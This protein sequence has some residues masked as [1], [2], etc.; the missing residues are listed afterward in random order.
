MINQTA[1]E[2][3]TERHSRLLDNWRGWAILF[4]LAG[5]FF[6]MRGVNLG[7]LGVELFFALSGRLMADLLFVKRVE[8]G[9]FFY[10][11]ITRVIPVSWLFLVIALIFF[12][13]GPIHLDVRSALASAA[14]VVNYTHLIGIGAQVVDHYWSLCI[15]E[16]SYLVLGSMAWLFRRHAPTKLR[17]ATVCLVL[18]A[19]MMLNGWRLW[20]AQHD[21]YAVY[22]RSDVRAATIFASVGLRLAFVGGVPTAWRAPWI[23]FAALVLGLA[24]NVNHV[25]DPIKY[26]AGSLSIALAIN[27][28]EN[29]WPGAQR[30]L[31]ARPIAWFGLI[32]YSLYIWQQPFYYCV[33]RYGAVP[34]LAGALV[35]ATVVSYL[36]EQPVRRWLNARGRRASTTPAL[37]K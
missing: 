3:T 33:D 28:L 36:F 23:P 9:N 11:R 2:A 7:R 10:R 24:L 30:F 19:L 1:P 16:H 18:A 17:P 12:P 21:Y 22:W 31:R 27:S 26:S 4:V 14:M 37:V 29:A 8:L 15:E 34:M 6:E 25:P 13:P 5:H 32:S 20:H 35:T